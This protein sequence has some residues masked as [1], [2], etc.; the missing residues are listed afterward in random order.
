MDRKNDFGG[1]DIWLY[2]SRA[3]GDC[4][5]YRSTGCNVHTYLYFSAS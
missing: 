2:H 5:H 3:S 1:G 4:G